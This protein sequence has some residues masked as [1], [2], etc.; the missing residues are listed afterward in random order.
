MHTRRFIG[1]AVVVASLLAGTA[2]G[3]SGGKDDSQKATTTT[4][5]SHATTTAATTTSTAAA[6]TTTTAGS[7]GGVSVTSWA[8]G[9]CGSFAGWLTAI[10]TAGSSMSANP[11]TSVTAARTQILALFDTVGTETDSLVNAIK[12][13]GPPDMDKGAQLSTD[14]QQKFQEFGTET[15]AARASVAAASTS[16]P[17]AFQAAVQAAV[18]KFQTDVGKIGDSFSEIDTK[19]PDPQF[20][21]ALSTACADLP[22]G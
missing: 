8:G 17:T 1:S 11:P 18:D 7:S 16:D 19:Y 9:F 4:T 3:A 15:A 22:T 5:A 14:L 2:C 13:L 6:K 10:K 12:A 21:S 20:Q